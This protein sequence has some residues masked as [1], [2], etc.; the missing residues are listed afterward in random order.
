MDHLRSGIGLQSYAQKDPKV[1]YKKQG[2]RAFET[3]WT[4]VADRVTD[5]IFRLEE[6]NPEFLGSL[7][8]V[9]SA[10][11]ESAPTPEAEPAPGQNAGVDRQAVEP[12]RN[13]GERVGRNDPCPCGSGKKF[14]NCCMHK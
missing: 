13:R 2:M 1:E 5:A 7:W 3:M 4:S 6:A 11:H 14:K 8:K 9:S 12:I 10:V